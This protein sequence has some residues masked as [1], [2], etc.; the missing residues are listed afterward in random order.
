MHNRYAFVLVAMLIL[1]ASVHAQECAPVLPGAAKVEG[2]QYRLA[3]RTEPE[4]VVLG[5]HF[6]MEVV[7]CGK[8]GAESIEGLKVDAV[9]P[10]HRHGMNYRA[11]AKRLDAGRYRFDGLMFHMPGRWDLVF[12]V[13]GGGKTERLV[14]EDVLRNESR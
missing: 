10:E 13:S 5:R 12:D 7:I 3:Y 8:T 2:V 14:R 4:K 1:S 9:M 11:T 6:S